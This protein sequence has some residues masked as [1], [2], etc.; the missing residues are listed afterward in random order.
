VSPPTENTTIK[1]IAIFPNPAS[2]YIFLQ[3]P[4]GHTYTTITVFNQSG[5]R[6]FYTTL[7]AGNEPNRYEL[8]AH[9]PQGFYFVQITGKEASQ[10]VRMVKE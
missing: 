9:L 8:P 3:L 6:V 4:K 10:T 5:Q 2:K 1:E 7:K